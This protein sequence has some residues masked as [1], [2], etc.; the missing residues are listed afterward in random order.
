MEKL[1]TAHSHLRNT[2]G[3]KKQNCGSVFQEIT[4]EKKKMEAKKVFGS[5][6][7]R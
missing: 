5:S 6:L 2:C 7:A 3:S 1:N 4:G